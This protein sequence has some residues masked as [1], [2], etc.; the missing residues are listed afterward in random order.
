MQSFHKQNSGLV[1]TCLLL[2]WVTGDKNLL[3]TRHFPEYA[4]DR[5]DLWDVRIMIHVG[6]VLIICKYFL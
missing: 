4:S 2:V 6:K 5:C 1:G 3:Q